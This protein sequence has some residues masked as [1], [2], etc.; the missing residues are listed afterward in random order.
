MSYGEAATE[1]INDFELTSSWTTTNGGRCMW[2]FCKRNG[3]DY[4]I[5]KF[6]DPKYPLESGPF[7]GKVRERVLD[8]CKEFE[9]KQQRLQTE[10][11]KRTA[12]GGNLVVP[13]KF[14]RSGTSYYKITPRIDVSG[15]DISEIA[16]LDLE[17]K[18]LL[19][20]T[21]LSSVR[22]LHLCEIVHGD[23]KPDN[24]LI[25]KTKKGDLIARII[26]LDDSY[27]SGEVPEDPEAVVGTIPYYSPELLQYVTEASPEKRT[28]VGTAN[29]IF[30]LGLIFHEYIYGTKVEHSEDHAYPSQ[31]LIS[32]S[33]IRLCDTPSLRLF[34]PILDSMLASCPTR[35][36][37]AQQLF[38][39]ISALEDPS[40][41][42]PIEPIPPTTPIDKPSLRGD[43]SKPSDT[44]PLSKPEKGTGRIPIASPF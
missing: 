21:V 20:K 34:H 13:V 39:Q 7:K 15:L 10:L 24:I 35:R 31:A 14:F 4:F 41:K 37:T 26:D 38:T 30:A 3:K 6:I 40:R 2:T 18:K 33:E 11:K 16:E 8:T 25:Q 28:H 17:K 12:P 19:L 22:L 23:L 1:R 42:I 44:E 5:K 32:D 9:S 29:D 36:K 27:F 43:L